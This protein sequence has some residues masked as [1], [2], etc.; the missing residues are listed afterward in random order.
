MYR[1]ET[2][3]FLV[4]R[5][6]RPD[7]SPPPWRI[8]GRCYPHPCHSGWGKSPQLTGPEHLWTHEPGYRGGRSGNLTFLLSLLQNRLCDFQVTKFI[9]MP[10]QAVPHWIWQNAGCVPTNKYFV[11]VPLD[12]AHK[13]FCKHG[14]FWYLSYPN[15]INLHMMQC[16]DWTLTLQEQNAFWDVSLL[17]PK[18]KATGTSGKRGLESTIRAIIASLVETLAPILHGLFNST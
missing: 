8:V 17:L 12:A 2:I 10:A 18:L 4:I 1:R 9:D 3:F 16:C 11:P 7:Y 15:H 14:F 5:G 13:H 6:S